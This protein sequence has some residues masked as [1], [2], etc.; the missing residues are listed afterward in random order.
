MGDSKALPHPEKSLGQHW[1]NDSASLGSM[2]AA[3]CVKANDVVLEIGPG[4]GALTEHLLAR[5]AEVVAV[6][7]DQNL[8]TAL[9]KKFSTFASTKFWVEYG[10]IRKYDLGNMPD[11]YKIVANIPYYLTANLLRI[12]TDTAHK[13]L[14]AV[15]LVQQEVAERVAS[16]P[17]NLSLIAVLVQLEYEVSLGR[18]VPASLFQPP[19]KVDSQILVLVKRSQPLWVDADRTS[20]TRLLK[21]GFANRRK[22]LHNSLSA[23]LHITKDRAASVLEHAN[24]PKQSRAQELSLNEW[25]KLHEACKING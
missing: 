11:E 19:P 6:E 12:L 15:L 13:P 8:I 4:E 2:C 7:F 10:D 3:A 22:T 20:F 24:I 25:K 18:I 23:G 14:M 1:L 9:R 16:R 5:G 17:G 21:A